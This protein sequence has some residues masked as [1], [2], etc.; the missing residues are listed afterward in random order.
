MSFPLLIELSPWATAT[1]NVVA[2]AAIHAGTGYLV[3]RLPPSRLQR[4]GLLLRARRL[5]RDGRAYQRLLRVNR[6]KDRVPE[7]GALFS[8]GVSKRHISGAFGRAGL[9]RFVVET[10]R[11]EWGHWLAMAAG[12]LAGLWN[13]ALGVVLMVTYGVVVNLPFIVIQRYNRQRAQR[14]LR[15]RGV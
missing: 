6:W 7:A 13:S 9:D 11:A 2:W 15:R 5:E 4:D 8:G 1:A 12:P 14:V 3:H 10:R